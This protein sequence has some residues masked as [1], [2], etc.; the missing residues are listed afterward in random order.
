MLPTKPQ[1]IAAFEV[2]AKRHGITNPDRVLTTR[3]WRDE[4]LKELNI[5]DN[6]QAQDTALHQ[7]LNL[8]KSK[9]LKKP[10]T[11]PL[12]RKAAS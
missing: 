9:A 3:C 7:L 2:I 4:F 11:L 12:N 8:R 1:L 6:E 5:T 10:A